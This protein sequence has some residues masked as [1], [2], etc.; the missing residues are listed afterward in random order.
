MSRPGIYF[1]SNIAGNLFIDHRTVYTILFGLWAMLA[2]PAGAQIS[3]PGSIEIEEGGRVWIEGSASVVNYTCRAERLSGNGTVDNIQYPEQSVTDGGS[4]VIEVSIP[5]K[6]LECGKRA[7]NR[8]M[9]EALKAERYESIYYRLL[10]ATLNES[11]IELT[12]GNGA[13]QQGDG[14]MQIR[15]RGILEIA[16]VTDTTTVDVEGK[17]LSADRFR[18]RGSK[19]VDMRAHDVTPP[20]ALMGLIKASSEITVHFDVTVKLN[21]E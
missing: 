2:V 14:W 10:S 11:N 19:Q 12:N 1:P 3:S 8:D 6:A 4:V 7:M 5:V 17:L 13:P 21:N 9:Y 20:T 16:G 15:T 18:V